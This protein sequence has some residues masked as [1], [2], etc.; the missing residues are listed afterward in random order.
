MALASKTAVRPSSYRISNLKMIYKAKD[1]SEIV[2]IDFGTTSSVAATI[3]SGEAAILVELPSLVSILAT[4]EVVAGRRVEGSTC[5]ES[6]KRFIG[7]NPEEFAHLSRHSGVEFTRSSSGQ[8]ALCVNG[9]F[10]YPFELAG[11]LLEAVKL[12]SPIP[13]SVAVLTV[14]AYFDN[15]ARR[16]IFLAAELAGIKV[17]RIITEPTAAAYAYGLQNN[18]CGTYLVYDFGGGTFDVSLLSMKEG[19]FKVLGVDG[20]SALGGDDLD[21]LLA[22]YIRDACMASSPACLS[23]EDLV[24]AAKAAKEQVGQSGSFTV[25]L[26][27]DQRKPVSV[28]VSLETLCSIAEPLVKRTVGIAKGLFER[29]FSPKLS[30]ILLVGGSSKLSVV[31]D[32]LRHVFFDVPILGDVD[33]ERIVGFGAAWQ[34]HNLMRKGSDLLIDVVPLSLGLE[35]ADGFVDVIIPRNSSLPAC[36]TRVFT[37]GLDGQTKMQFNVVQGERELVEG[38]ISLAR[39]SLDGIPPLPRGRAKVEVTFALDVSG[40]LSVQAVEKSM[41]A[42]Q[43]VTIHSSYGLDQEDI[44]RL[45][46]DSIKHAQEDFNL[47]SIASLEQSAKELI[48]SIYRIT[49]AEALAHSNPELASQIEK[50]EGDIRSKSKLDI[51]SSL[52]SLRQKSAELFL[53]VLDSSLKSKV[54]GRKVEELANK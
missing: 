35:L 13:I 42:V 23:I 34:A 8:P 52:A 16:E 30:G 47:R 10:F 45:L 14:P 38:C 28:E 54:I 31:P 49:P 43:E 27:T 15:K 36:A 41:H 48:D 46:I 20:D 33:P 2:G 22:R 11:K 21:F 19:I 18:S 39:F 50:L 53:N 32:C 7:R 4:G 44:N 17:L 40:V 5:V 12:N 1:T 3:Q 26:S 29:C 9:R 25:N 51:S 24:G 37:T 6:I